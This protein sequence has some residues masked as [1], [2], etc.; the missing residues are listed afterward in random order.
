MDP[1]AATP[2]RDDRSSFGLPGSASCGRPP[3]CP[4]ALCAATSD[5][6]VTRAFFPSSRVASVRG[7]DTSGAAGAQPAKHRDPAGQ[8]TSNCRKTCTK[9]HRSQSKLARSKARVSIARSDD[10]LPRGGCQAP[11]VSRP[12]I[13]PANPR[14]PPPPRPA[15]ARKISRPAPPVQK[16]LARKNRQ[17]GVNA[18]PPRLPQPLAVSRISPDR[19]ASTRMYPPSSSFPTAGRSTSETSARRRTRRRSRRTASRT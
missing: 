14:R 3:P 18:P 19:V 13:L 8:K 10:G 17:L 16:C 4:F 15:S 9:R 6:D 12:Q 7:A 2:A 11:G 5:V 1:R